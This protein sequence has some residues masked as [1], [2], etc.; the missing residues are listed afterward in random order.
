MWIKH[1]IIKIKKSP[2]TCFHKLR[3]Y[4]VCYG[5]ETDINE[6]KRMEFGKCK[7]CL[8]INEDLDGCLSCNPKRFQR[9]FD[10]WTSGNEVID[11]LIQDNQLSVRRH[12][13]LEWIPYDKFTNIKY[14]AEGGFAKVYSAIWIDGQ[15][16]KWSRLSN[17]WRRNGS[18]TIALKVLNNSENV[19]EDFLN[20]V[21][22]KNLYNK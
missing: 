6:K 11:K 22:K 8:K 9:D 20:E 1:E 4:C 15:I 12:G 13:L 5:K 18:L 2:K 17:S 19:S 14:I 3:S 16:K 10:K 21:C 7:E